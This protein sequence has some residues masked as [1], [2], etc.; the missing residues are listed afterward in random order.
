M[1]KRI[2][3]SVSKEQ[4]TALLK[5]HYAE[6]CRCIELIKD[7]QDLTHKYKSVLEEQRDEMIAKLERYNKGPST[8]LDKISVSINESGNPEITAR[9]EITDDEENCAIVDIIDVIDKYKPE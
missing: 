4:Y 5:D 9:F 2:N 3:E 8:H 6:V 1:K 7:N